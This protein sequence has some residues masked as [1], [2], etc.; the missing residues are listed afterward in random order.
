MLYLNDEGGQHVRVHRLHLERAVCCKYS[1]V[2]EADFLMEGGADS[3]K[4]E[5]K[6][7]YKPEDDESD[8]AANGTNHPLA[9]ERRHHD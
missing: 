3:C 6:L 2:V 4:Q 9:R 5:L 1:R 8:V 7:M